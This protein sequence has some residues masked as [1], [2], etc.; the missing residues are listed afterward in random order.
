MFECVRK[1]EWVFGGWRNFAGVLSGSMFAGRALTAAGDSQFSN[2]IPSQHRC[3]ELWNPL[4]PFAQHR[5]SAGADRLSSV[6]TGQ[7]VEF[8]PVRGGRLRGEW[9]HR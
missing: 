2:E 5:C 6:G 8:L 7:L 3:D 4:T 9:F 1:A